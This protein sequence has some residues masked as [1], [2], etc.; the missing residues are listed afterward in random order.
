MSIEVGDLL[1]VACSWIADGRDTMVNVHTL[2]VES[3]G[4]TSTDTEFMDALADALLDSAYDLITSSMPNNIL[5]TTL[6]GQNVTKDELLPIVAW[7]ADG[8]AVQDALARQVTPLVCYNTATPRRQGRSYLPPFTEA[9]LEDDGNWGTTTLAAIVAFAAAMML[10]ISDGDINVYRVVSNLLGT[11]TL[12][13]T[14]ST[15]PVAP[16]TQR[17]RTPGRGG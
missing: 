1:R 6:S 7:D 2:L 3:V 5:A 8:T 17:R 9:G 12:Y 16:R 14:S 4:T 11:S 10:G 15:V 13:P